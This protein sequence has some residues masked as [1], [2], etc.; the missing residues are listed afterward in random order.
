MQEHPAPIPCHLMILDAASSLC[1]SVN[2]QPAFF[3]PAYLQAA[4]VEVI[5]V[6]VFYPE[7]THIL[8][9][10]VYRTVRD[11]PGT[12]AVHCVGGSMTMAQLV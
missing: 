1:I 6:P 5:P 2:P 4:G 8:G 3:V 7:A 11:V 10:P 12:S 9:R